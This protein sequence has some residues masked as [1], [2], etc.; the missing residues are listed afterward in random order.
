MPLLIVY[1]ET[2]GMLKHIYNLTDFQE[3][4]KQR[5][6]LQLYSYIANG[7]DDE[8]SMAHNRSAFDDWM[9]TPRM[10]QDV[11]QRSQ[12]IQLFGHRY[13][14]PFGISPVG[15]AAMW[16]YRGDIVLAQTA[17]QHNVPAIMSG[18]SLIAMEEVAKAAPNTWFQAY[19]PGEATRIQELIARIKN[20]GFPVL[21]LTVDLPV[22]VNPERYA[23]NGFS[24][25]LKPSFSLAW[26]G[27]THPRWLVGTF[28]RTL[29][30]HGMPHFENWRAERGA[31]ILSPTVQRDFGAR[32]HL[33]WSHIKTV[34]ALWDGPLV[35]KGIM[36]KEDAMQAIQVGVDGIII[37]NHGGRQL[38]SSCSPLTVLPE[39]AE[40]CHG[41]L[42]LMIDSGFRRGTDVLKAIGLGADCVFNGRSFNFAAALAGSKGVS[43]AISILRTE[44]HRNMAHLGI[45]QL[46]EIDSSFLRPAHKNST[47]YLL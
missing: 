23:K 16:C 19:L 17:Q 43:H 13:D 20:A 32:D 30:T 14:S 25:P 9:F 44:I 47:P 12:H 38:D 5:L 3:P 39:I 2:S 28:L 6:P 42:T 24:S 1:L 36:R 35:L 15:L 29:A 33:S 18:A 46:D 45:N 40:A 26:Q 21:V 4:A 31:P 34:R 22:S 27:I 8:K 41:R 11:S 37:S 10:L 7:A